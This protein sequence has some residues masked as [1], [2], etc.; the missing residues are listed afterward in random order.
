MSFKDIKAKYQIPDYYDDGLQMV[1]GRIVFYY[2]EGE[3]EHCD[4]T[5]HPSGIVEENRMG[6]V[7]DDAGYQFFNV[8][9]LPWRS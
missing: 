3:A 6:L 8:P 9:W 5:I 7:N 2:C 1:D 4:I